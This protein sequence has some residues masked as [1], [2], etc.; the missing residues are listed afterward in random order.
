MGEIRRE[1]CMDRRADA[2]G[3]VDDEARASRGTD[4]MKEE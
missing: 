4:R 3:I 2:Q 1:E